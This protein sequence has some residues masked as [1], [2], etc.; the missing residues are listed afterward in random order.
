MFSADHNQHA[1]EILVAVGD[2]GEIFAWNIHDLFSIAIDGDEAYREQPF[3]K[4]VNTELAEN[5]G[6]NG[7]VSTWGI[8]LHRHGLLAVSANNHRITVY[9]LWKRHEESTV[10][11]VSNYLGDRQRVDLAGHLHN[12]PCI[13]FDS[14]GRYLASGS[15]DMTCRLWDLSTLRQVGQRSVTRTADGDAW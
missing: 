11:T 3:F 4:K 14:S 5:E 10:E 13:D 15:I 2:N 1:T 7:G 12:V 6:R 9:N 8:A